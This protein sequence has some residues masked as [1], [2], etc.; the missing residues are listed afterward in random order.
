MSKQHQPNQ[1]K[2]GNKY[3]KIIKENLKSLIPALL[4]KVLGLKIHRIEDL[5]AVKMQTTLEREPDFLHLVYDEAFPEGRIIHLEFESANETNME[6]RMLEYLGMLYRK[7]GLPIEQHL[8]FMG[9]S[10]STMKRKIEFLDIKYEYHI[11]NLSEISYKKFIYSTVP[12]EVILSILANKEDL[13][14]VALIRLILR[15]LVELKGDSLEGRRQRRRKG[16]RT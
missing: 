3:D 8:I 16:R 5:P 7:Y 9:N 2:E 14:P 1:R 13:Q 11:H 12:E 10:P 6:R 4:S 15:R